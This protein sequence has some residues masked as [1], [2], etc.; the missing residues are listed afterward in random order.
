[1]SQS[2]IY[3]TNNISKK[4]NFSNSINSKLI[5]TYDKSNIKIPELLIKYFKNKNNSNN[6]S[7]QMPQY[8]K[9]IYPS[10]DTLLSPIEQLDLESEPFITVSLCLLFD[11]ILCGI[12][13]SKIYSIGAHIECRFLHCLHP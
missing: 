10:S 5:D 12:S 6:I 8:L 11:F 2:Y 4:N 1:M 3:N 13:S 7:N 9:K